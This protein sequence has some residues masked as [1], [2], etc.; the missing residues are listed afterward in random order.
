MIPSESGRWRSFRIGSGAQKAWSLT[1]SPALQVGQTP[2]QIAL[3]KGH[4]D[5]SK[6]LRMAG[7]RK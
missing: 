5:I 3:E 7:A 6:M 4:E 2:L 1:V